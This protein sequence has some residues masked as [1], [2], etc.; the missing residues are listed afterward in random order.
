MEGAAFF[1]GSKKAVKHLGFF[2]LP[3]FFTFFRLVLCLDAAAAGPA[4]GEEDVTIT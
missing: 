4:A 2:P 3:L 1:N